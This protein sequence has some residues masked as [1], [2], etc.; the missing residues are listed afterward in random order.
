MEFRRDSCKEIKELSFD[1]CPWCCGNRWVGP[2]YRENSPTLP[3][4][5]NPGHYMDVSEFLTAQRTM[6]M[7]S[8]EHR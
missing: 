2:T 7:E 5:E 3:D 4:P 6:K 1:L 8:A